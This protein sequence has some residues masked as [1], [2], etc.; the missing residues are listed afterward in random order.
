MLRCACVMSSK[1][2]LQKIKTELAKDDHD[3]MI[4]GTMRTALASQKLKEDRLLLYSLFTLRT[5]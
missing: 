3:S 1:R 4:Q 5:E 2:H